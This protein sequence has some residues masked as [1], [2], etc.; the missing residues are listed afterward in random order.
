MNDNDT[1]KTEKP[2]TGNDHR[3]RQLDAVFSKTAQ[4]LQETLTELLSFGCSAFH[5]DIGIIS[6]IQDNTYTIM[7]VF[8]EDGALEPGN[9][10]QLE[11]TYCRDTIEKMQSIAFEN[12]S[13]CEWKSHP[14][15]R[16]FGLES[17]IGTPI[18][19]NNEAYGT[20]NFSSPA[21]RDIKFTVEDMEFIQM[22]A[23]WI[24]TEIARDKAEQQ[25]KKQNMIL[26]AIS[27]SQ[28]LFIANAEPGKLFDDMLTDLLD[29]TDSEYG[30]IGEIH[31]TP[32]GNRY[33]KT[34]AL[35][36]IAWNDETRKFYDE[37]APRGLEFYNLDTLFGEVIRSEQP[38]I[39][40][41]PSSH[42]KA[43][44]LPDGHPAMHSFLGVPI[45]SNNSMVGMFG[46]ANAP[47]GYSQETL[48][49]LAPLVSTCGNIIT[50]YHAHLKLQS[51][52][53]R[54]RSL[55]N[56]IPGATYRCAQDDD[57]TT[58]FISNP[59]EEICGYPASDFIENRTRSYASIIHPE[60]SEM[61][62]FKVN[63]A[64]AEH[65]PWEIEYRIIHRNGMV[66]Y[67]YEKGQSVN[68]IDGTRTFLDGFILDITERKRTENIKDEF[69][70]TVSHEL[71]TPVTSIR[72]ALGLLNGG[73]LASLPENISNLLT[74]ASQNT[75]RLLSL[76]NDLLDMQKLELGNIEYQKESMEVHDFIIHAASMNQPYADQYNVQIRLPEKSDTAP[77][78][79]DRNRLM[80]V[81]S[82]LISNA[83]KFSPAGGTINIDYRQNNNFIEISVSDQG[84]GIP[85][86]FHDRLFEK[87]TQADTS[88]TRNA[89]GTGLGLSICKHIVEAQNGEIRFETSPGNGTSFFFTVPVAD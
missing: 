34:H 59:I 5:M 6:L 42:P 22:M 85:E 9:T 46:I 20:L 15:Y 40:N 62:G 37:N 23:R 64:I 14:A 1:L 53:L 60:D 30:F 29:L 65:T 54:Y 25:L 73:I 38:L 66:R 31:L 82:N 4:N 27:K 10:F 17:Y 28:D 57:W 84:N 58:F 33:L 63:S 39:A 67:V 43:G 13:S 78:Y 7:H 50:A 72:G 86:E 32:E 41:S 36:N 77:V 11:N 71:R 21:P 75:D 3:I 79:A 26:A 45:I 52:E 18:I 16:E 12:A 89:S 19:V 2:G 80:Q 51:Q 88:D 35:T 87:F 44:G 47:G 76:I 61:V 68:S 48:N 24:S 69:I 49:Y 74:I 70:S 55:V 56:N 8:S 83:A 81:I